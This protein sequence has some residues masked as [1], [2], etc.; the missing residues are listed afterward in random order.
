MMELKAK[1]PK[2]EMRNPVKRVGIE[3]IPADWNQV[4]ETAVDYIKNKPVIPDA[5]IQA[6]WN[7]ESQEEVDYIKNKPTALSEFENDVGFITQGLPDASGLADGTGLVVVNE[8]FRTTEGFPFHGELFDKIEWVSPVPETYLDTVS[9][10]TS[11]FYKISEK[12]IKQE[13]LTKDYVVASF[14]VISGGI[15][16]GMVQYTYG[17][18]YT[19]IGTSTQPQGKQLYVIQFPIEVITQKNGTTTTFLSSG[20]WIRGVKNAYHYTFQSQIADIPISETFLPNNVPKYNNYFSIEKPAD[21]PPANFDGY[22]QLVAEGLAVRLTDKPNETTYRYYLVKYSDSYLGLESLLGCYYKR[23]DNLIY[24]IQN[25]HILHNEDGYIVLGSGGYTAL[26]IVSVGKGG[27]YPSY[28]LEG[29]NINFPSKGIWVLIAVKISSQTTM[30]HPTNIYREVKKLDNLFLDT[31]YINGLIEAKQTP[32]IQADWNQT[33]E[34]A[35]DY[36]KNK[37]VEEEKV[38]YII[39]YN[40][41][42]SNMNMFT[43]TNPKE[44]VAEMVED[45]KTGKANIIRNFSLSYDP[46]NTLPTEGTIFPDYQF[47]GYEDA[48]NMLNCY[49][50]RYIAFD[51]NKGQQFLDIVKF[52]LIKSNNNTSFYHY[53]VPMFDA[54]IWYG[55]TNWNKEAYPHAVSFSNSGGLWGKENAKAVKNQRA[56][57]LSNFNFKLRVTTHNDN[58]W[59]SPVETISANSLPRFIGESEKLGKRIVVSFADFT[60]TDNPTGTIDMYDVVKVPSFDATADEGKVLKIVSGVPTWVSEE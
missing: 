44:D 11:T 9:D 41:S 43:L 12:V 5:Q 24:P 50:F 60:D 36:I 20:I 4:D 17:D 13:F 55:D 35:L 27:V 10:G 57:W 7:Q 29:D 25:T 34:T 42:I 37:P 28:Y 1:H 21:F 32:Q 48:S 8:E 26:G 45:I 47:W 49:Y 6:D 22:D 33:D 54:V 52:T 2:M 14:H 53:Y 46:I 51:T 38:D 56:G 18:G 3:Q 59:L 31:D 30:T 58:V 16:M 39:N 15:E 23:S 19:A 40:R